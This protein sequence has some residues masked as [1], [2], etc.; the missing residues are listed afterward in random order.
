[1]FQFCEAV[2]RSSL[3]RVS[4]PIIS[5][6]L[7]YVSH[8]RLCSRL[9]EV[10]ESRSDWAPIILKARK[11]QKQ[12]CQV[13]EGSHSNRNYGWEGLRYWIRY[14]SC[15]PS[16]YKHSPVYKRVLEKLLEKCVSSQKGS[17]VF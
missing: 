17:V 5:V 4:G 9:L 15:E 10:L 3:C 14:H 8:V 12:C 1:M 11:Q 2:S 13:T 16:S 7:D 6:L